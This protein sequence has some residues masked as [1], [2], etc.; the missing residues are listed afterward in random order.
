M[1]L[2]PISP[3]SKDLHNLKVNDVFFLVI[4]RRYLVNTQHVSH[5]KKHGA[6]CPCMQMGVSKIK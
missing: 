3:P 2:N 1:N 4:F 5:G 6:K